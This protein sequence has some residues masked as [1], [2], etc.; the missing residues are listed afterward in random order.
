MFEQCLY[1]NSNALARTVSRMWAE[2]YK[3]FDLSPPHAFLVK[4]VLTNPGISPRGLA[5]DLSLSRSTVTRFLDSLEKNGFVRRESI[6]KDGRE[7]QV[8]P[9]D[10]AKNIRDQLNETRT[11][12]MERISTLL[13]DDEMPK[14]VA[15]LRKTRNALEKK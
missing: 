3:K 13:G 5:E 11:E 7:I 6:G 1:F 8:Y 14:T 12:L 9:T 4:V 10:K 2:A 15:T